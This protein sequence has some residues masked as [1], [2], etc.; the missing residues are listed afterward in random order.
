M[1]TVSQNLIQA[2]FTLKVEDVTG[3]ALKYLDRN[4]TLDDSL[5]KEAF[6]II[7]KVVYRRLKKATIDKIK[8]LGSRKHDSSDEIEYVIDCLFPPG[9]FSNSQKGYTLGRIE[10]EIYEQYGKL[11]EIINFVSLDTGEIR[12]YRLVGGER[13]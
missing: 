12:Q 9:L 13:K 8:P 2:V 3:Y 7:Y 10:M 1:T 11:Y 4:M 6:K 5:V